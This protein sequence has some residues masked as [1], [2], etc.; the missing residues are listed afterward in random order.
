MILNVSQPA[1]EILRKSNFICANDLGVS[2][3]NGIELT[4]EI[5]AEIEGLIRAWKISVREAATAALAGILER[6]G[7]MAPDARPAVH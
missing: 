5:R 2:I 6:E 4:P 3:P 1:A 7:L